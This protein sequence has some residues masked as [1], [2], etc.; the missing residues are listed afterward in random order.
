MT[1]YTTEQRK[2]KKREAG[3]RWRLAHPEYKEKQKEASRRY[4]LAHPERFRE[5][6]RRSR[7][8]HRDQINDKQR[9]KYAAKRIAAG[10]TY[11]SNGVRFATP[12][13]ASMKEN[14][15]IT[16]AVATPI[17]ATMGIVELADA[18][19]FDGGAAIDLRSLYLRKLLER[20]AKI[21]QSRMQH[22]TVGMVG[23]EPD[24]DKPMS[25]AQVKEHNHSR[26]SREM[27]KNRT[28]SAD[29][30]RR[31]NK[32][33]KEAKAAVKKRAVAEIRPGLRGLRQSQVKRIPPARG[34]TADYM[35]AAGEKV[36]ASSPVQERWSDH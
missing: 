35:R 31:G 1:M 19:M 4:Q 15:A 21:W 6:V 16:I 11:T 14:R 12:R 17:I 20:D 8:K 26:K 18:I 30:I 33:V 34:E 28:L 5:N 29:R 23:D 36:T 13:V 7:R 22:I 2:E 25:S 3:R 10:R 24:D 32:A 27:S 9:E